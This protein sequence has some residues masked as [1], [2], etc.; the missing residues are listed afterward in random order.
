MATTTHI[1][2]L[3]YIYY[4]PMLHTTFIIQH[5]II[6]KTFNSLFNFRFLGNNGSPTS[7]KVNNDTIQKY[8]N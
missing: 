8:W 3:I 4:H 6:L 1:H 7:K 2:L 5:F